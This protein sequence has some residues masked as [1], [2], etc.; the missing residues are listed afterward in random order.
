MLPKQIRIYRDKGTD[1]F[2]LKALVSA[3][4]QELVHQTYSITFADRQLLQTATWHE[5]TKLLIFPGGRD[6]PYQ[7]ALQGSGNQQIV[8][9]VQQGGSFLGICAGAYYASSHIEFEKGSPLEVIASRDLCFFPGC[10]VGPAY[11]PGTFGYQN[12]K[13]ALIASLELGSETS[14]SYYHGGC[15]FIGE[16]NNP[17]ISIL[18]RYADLAN[19]PPAIVRCTVGQGQAVLCGVHP[20]YSAYHN[21]TSKHLPTPLFTAL[22]KIEPERRLVFTHLL[23]KLEV[24]HSHLTVN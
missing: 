1:P 3:L 17:N 7:E 22:R 6:I 20:E 13:G 10:A 24:V 4:Q 21:H 15:A 8:D 5:H 11:G 16:E 9:F 19:K 14:A 2:C 12:Q 18:A 23:R